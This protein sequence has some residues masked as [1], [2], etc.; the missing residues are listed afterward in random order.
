MD[1]DLVNSLAVD[2]ADAAGCG[3]APGFG[4]GV[5]AFVA[6]AG[7]D[8]YVDPAAVFGQG[9]VHA[10]FYELL[11]AISIVHATPPP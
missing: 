2:A 9:V 3:P 5:A 4:Y 10:L 7:A 1:V 6:E 8:A 11:G